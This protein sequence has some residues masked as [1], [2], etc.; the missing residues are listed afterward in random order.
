MR[1]N[2]YSDW[3]RRPLSSAVCPT[4][5]IWPED[6]AR[7]PDTA[8]APVASEEDFMNEEKHRIL[9]MLEEGKISA[10]QAARLM[11]ALDKSDSRPRENDIKRKWLHIRVQEDGRDKVNMR[12]PLALLKFGFKLAPKVAREHA[13]NAQRKAERAKARAERERER[14]VRRARKAADKVKR[15]LSG[16]L[17]DHP[18]VDVDE[19]INGAIEESMTE[20]EQAIDEGLEEARQD[21]GAHVRGG[22]ASLAGQ[23]FDLDLDSILEM[24]QSE[25]FDGKILDLYDEDDDEHVTITLE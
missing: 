24:A 16:K 25:G 5:D 23:D 20:M 4:P 22:F 15:D 7:M 3:M 19:I 12:V 8:G 21:I 1:T 6:S 18:G 9:K 2:S 14:A 11:E 13:K 10:D 17:G